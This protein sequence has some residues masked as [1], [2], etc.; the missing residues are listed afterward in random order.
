MT[1]PYKQI[2][3]ETK[4]QL[5]PI[6]APSLSFSEISQLFDNTKVIVHIREHFTYGASVEERVAIIRKM[7][8]NK[9]SIEAL[10]SAGCLWY[11]LPD[12]QHKI[13]VFKY[14]NKRY[15][16]ISTEN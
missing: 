11:K 2:Y 6:D 3:E 4:I 14:P 1:S 8:E 5:V 7:P 9:I 12:D 16:F 15:A 13:K 10:C